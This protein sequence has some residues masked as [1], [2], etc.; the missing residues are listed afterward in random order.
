MFQNITL[1]LS[2]IGTLGTIYSIAYNIITSRVNIAAQIKFID[3]RKPYLFGYII[4]ENRSNST[5]SISNIELIIN[6]KPYFF[7]NH[8][9][10]VN[11]NLSKFNGHEN[12]YDDYTAQIPFTL[13]TYGALGG[14]FLSIS[15]DTSINLDTIGILRIGTNRNKIIE[16][17]IPLCDIPRQESTLFPQS[18]NHH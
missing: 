13:S 1:I 12:Y 16:I 9:H 10:L 5:V 2:I 15:S 14:Y 6:G 18:N 17:E 7:I 8:P 4:V 3:Y 11:H